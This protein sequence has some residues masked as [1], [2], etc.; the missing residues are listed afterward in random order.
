M[1][2]VPGLVT[3]PILVAASPRVA[4]AIV[5]VDLIARSIETKELTPFRPVQDRPFDLG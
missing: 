4:L 2:E 5:V 1:L 3:A